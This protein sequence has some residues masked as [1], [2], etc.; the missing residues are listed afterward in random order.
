MD[1]SLFFISNFN[2]SMFLV[3]FLSN[4]YKKNKLLIIIDKAIFDLKISSS[5][6]L[7]SNNS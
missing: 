4:E 1:E 2:I 3:Q 5:L 7:V 6:I